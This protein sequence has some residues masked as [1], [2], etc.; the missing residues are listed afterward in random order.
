MGV[1]SWAERG[2]RRD[3]IREEM[4]PSLGWWVEG[5]GHGLGILLWEDGSH[6]LLNIKGVI[7]LGSQ[8]DRSLGC[9]VEKGSQGS[10]GRSQ[11]AL[12]EAA[13]VVKR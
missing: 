4:L 3:A 11:E 8:G 7:R 13:A 5:A 12:Q 6:R 9:S 1:L 2:T 10:T